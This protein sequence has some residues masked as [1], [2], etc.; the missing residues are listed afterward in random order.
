MMATAPA[1][2][3][4][5]IEVNSMNPNT[6]ATTAAVSAGGHEDRPDAKAPTKMPAA[7]VAVAPTIHSKRGT[8]STSS[9]QGSS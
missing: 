8:V 5:A 6:E 1:L 9:V 7:T 3:Q 4:F 2:S